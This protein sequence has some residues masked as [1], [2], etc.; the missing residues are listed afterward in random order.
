M[1]REA[2]LQFCKICTNHKK[3]FNLGIVCGLTNRT[4]DFEETCDLFEED[5]ELTAKVAAKVAEYAL[6]SKTASQGKRFANYLI[7]Q[8]FLVG[9]GMLVGVALGLILLYLFPDYLYMLDEDNRILEYLLGFIVAMIYYSFF[10]GFTGRSLGKFFTKTKVVTEVGDKPNFK[11]ILVRSLCRN[12]PFN[13]FSF[14]G[15]EAVGW[16]DKFSGTRVVDI[17]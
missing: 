3:D 13:A 6:G 5:A 2:H 16:H 9:C 10:E 12:I 4:A 17:D 8:V 14:L 11:T 7:D 15:S 1:T